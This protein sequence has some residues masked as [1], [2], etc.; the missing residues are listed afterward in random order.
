MGVNRNGTR[1]IRAIGHRAGT[2]ATIRASR[3]LARFFGCRTLD[4]RCG[5]IGIHGNDGKGP[6]SAPDCLDSIGFI[7]D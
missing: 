7:I 5:M 1:R 2:E 3:Q 6:P 4:V